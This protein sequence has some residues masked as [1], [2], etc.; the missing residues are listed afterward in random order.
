MEIRLSIPKDYY[1]S[2]L[3]L[4]DI[5]LLS[6]EEARKFAKLAGL[7]NRLAHEYNDLDEQKLFDAFREIMAALPRYLKA[8]DDFIAR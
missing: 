8:V 5:N 1:E 6:P 2:F 4:A 3:K 7:R